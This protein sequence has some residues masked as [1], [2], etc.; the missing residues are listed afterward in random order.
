MCLHK[1]TPIFLHI[2]KLISAG[3]KGVFGLATKFDN[4]FF[5][6]AATI[7]EALISK[8]FERLDCATYLPVRAYGCVYPRA[9]WGGRGHETA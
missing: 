9:F 6:I 4:G 3:G 2:A 8:P 7:R 5:L 1:I